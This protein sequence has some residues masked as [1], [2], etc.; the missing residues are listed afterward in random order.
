MFR[1]FDCTSAVVFATSPDTIHIAFDYIHEELAEETGDPEEVRLHREP[2][3][4]LDDEFTIVAPAKVAHHRVGGREYPRWVTASPERVQAVAAAV[5]AAS[6]QNAVAASAVATDAAPPVSTQ[7]TPRPT[8]QQATSPAKPVATTLAGQSSEPPVES[9][10]QTLVPD[11]RGYAI[12]QL[13]GRFYGLPKDSSNSDIAAS[14]VI[15]GE[16]AAAVIESILAAE[17]ARDEDSKAE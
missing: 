14:G 5:A 16:S 6:V 11:F 15:Q 9:A 12:L 1:V 13:G 10:P 8:T 4:T 3:E 17:Q 7:A 2:T